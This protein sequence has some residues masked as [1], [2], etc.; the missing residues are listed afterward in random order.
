MILTSMLRQLERAGVRSRAHR[1]RDSGLA[2]DAVTRDWFIVT[3]GSVGRLGLG[4]IASIIIARALGPEAFGM[5]AVLAAVAA[6]AGAGVDLG[7]TNAAVR[8]VSAAWPEHLADVSQIWGAFFWLRVIVAA[9][10]VGIGLALA[11]PLSSAIFGTPDYAN[12]LRLALLGVA[13]TALSGTVTSMLQ[14]TSRFG[15][16]S[17]VLLVNSGLT[18]VLAIGLAL[19]SQLTITTALLVLGIGTSLVSLALAYWLLPG[20]WRL[21]PPGRE[22]FSRHARDLS[23]YGAWLWVGSLLTILALYLDVLIVNHWMAP[24]IVGIYA[25]AVNLTVK[26]EVVNQSLYTVLLP[27]ASSL[28]SQADV[29][30]YIRRGLVRSGAIGMALLPILLLAGPLIGLFYGDAYRPAAGIVQGLLLVAI[31]NILL[32]PLQMLAF[33]YDRPWIVAATD[34]TRALTLLVAGVIL[35]PTLG[36]SGAVLAK[37][38]AAVAGGVIIIAFVVHQLRSTGDLPVDSE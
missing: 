19:T 2:L 38:A 8:R 30:S 27:A 10:I 16:L 15:R 35:V 6:F 26:V 7:L 22:A 23:R 32:T 18:V 1:L 4:L 31:F 24:A 13:A 36:T 25:L 37:L 11:G 3:G 33:T 14:A 9:G 34:G 29:R 12:Y 21:A 28:K 20:R 17:L 5:Y